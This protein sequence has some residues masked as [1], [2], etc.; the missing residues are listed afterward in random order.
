MLP[1][2][3]RRPCPGQLRRV[4]HR[5]VFIY[6]PEY[7]LLLHRVHID[8]VQQLS[9]GIGGP[10]RAARRAGRHGVLSGSFSSGFAG[11]GASLGGSVTPS[12]GA[13]GFAS[14]GFS[15]SLF[16]PPQAVSSSASSK[17][18]VKILRFIPFTPRSLIRCHANTRKIQDLHW[19]RPWPKPDAAH[20]YI[21]AGFQRKP[22]CHKQAHLYMRLLYQYHAEI[23]A[24]PTDPRFKA[25]KGARE[26]QN[27]GSPATCSHAFYRPKKPRG[28]PLG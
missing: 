2:T 10:Q 9:G 20:G 24:G 17:H 26:I 7:V 21:G 15:G 13:D 11:S 28:Q 12:P 1:Q 22:Q 4:F 27:H 16:C 8:P 3:G 23:Q 18:T 14:G 19:F 6:P 5:H 25:A